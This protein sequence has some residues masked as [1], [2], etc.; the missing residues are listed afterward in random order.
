MI[1]ENKNF[2]YKKNSPEIFSEG[3]FIGILV[4]LIILFD[5]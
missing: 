1:K 3:F 4:L 5:N 2:K